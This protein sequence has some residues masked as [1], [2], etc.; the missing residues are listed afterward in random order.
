MSCSFVIGVT[1]LFDG[2]S[3]AWFRGMTYSLVR[4]QVYDI[5]KTRIKKSTV[6]TS[7]TGQVVIAGATAGVIGGFVSNPGGGPLQR[8]H[9]RHNL[10][11]LVRCRH[12]PYSYASGPL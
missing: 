10:F 11:T 9:L 4:F 1:G 2:L 5:C 3:A 6:I 8:R 12:R 7:K